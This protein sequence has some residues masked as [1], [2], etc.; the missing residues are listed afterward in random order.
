MQAAED[1]FTFQALASYAGV[2]RRAGFD[3]MNVANNHSYDYGASGY[4]QTLAALEGARLE[5]QAGRTRCWSAGWGRCGW[6]SRASPPTRGRP[7][8][9]TRT[10]L[11]GWWPAPAAEPTS[12]WSSCTPERRA[13]Q[14]A[15]AGGHRGRVREN[16]GDTRG[17]A[18]AA[19]DAGADLVLG[20]GR[21]SCAGSSATAA[22]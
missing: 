8:C 10:A 14:D 20:S 3:V 9:A 21:T 12:W 17:F 2:F 4:G 13:P 7:T 6:R 5:T 11:G 16:R 19:V 1:C 22:A 15:H 18:Y